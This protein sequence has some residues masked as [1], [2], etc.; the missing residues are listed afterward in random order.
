MSASSLVWD[1]NRTAWLGSSPFEIILRFFED[2]LQFIFCK[3]HAV[4]WNAVEF[5][6]Q[7]RNSVQVARFGRISLAS[8]DA[9]DHIRN[10]CNSQRIAQI[11][12]DLAVQVL[13]RLQGFRRFV[14]C[15]HVFFTNSP[16]SSYK[17]PVTKLAKGWPL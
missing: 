2:F 6:D 14:F 5:F 1:A 7:L 11:R 10:C 15:A 3:S 13:L 8:H 16:H 12:L 17:F 9:S 4:R